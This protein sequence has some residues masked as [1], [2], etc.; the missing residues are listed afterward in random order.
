MKNLTSSFLRTSRNSRFR[1]ILPS[2]LQKTPTQAFS[3]SCSSTKTTCSQS[4]SN[5]IPIKKTEK[6]TSDFFVEQIFTGCLAEYSYYMDSEGE[7]IVIDPIYDHSIYLEL[8]AQRGA[9]IKYVF[10]THFHADFVSGHLNLAKKTGAQ[11][12]FGPLAKANFPFYLSKDQETFKFGKAQLQVLHTPGHTFESSSFV[13]KDSNGIPHSVY[14]GD[15]LFLGEVGRPDLAANESVHPE[16]MAKMLYDSI[17][18][19]LMLLPDNVLVFPGHGA[20]SPCGKSIGIGDFSTIGEQKVSNYAMMKDLKKEDFVKIASSN[21]AR[22]LGYMG[23]DVS[24]NKGN[25]KLREV[26]EIMRNGKKSYQEFQNMLKENKKLVILDTRE[27]ISKGLLKNTMNI[28]L[29]TTF[30]IYVGTMIDNEAPLFVVA[31]NQAKTEESIIR[32]LRVGYDKIVGYLDGGVETWVKNNGGLYNL[33]TIEAEKF[34]EIYEK[35]SHAVFLD[36]RNRAE[37]EDGI[38]KGAKLLPM[39]DIEEELEKGKL[40]HLKKEN[41][42]MYCRTGPR[43]ITTYTLFDK[44]GF[45]NVVNIL[46][47]YTKM[48]ELGFNFVKPT[49]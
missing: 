1:F 25:K 23:H 20:G 36:I 47:G 14:T 13:L 17:R 28:G 21:L 33:K 39:R 7:A 4:A 45:C 5:S 46:G 31:E 12:V 44:Y 19:K 2:L 26:E 41:I 29:N 43:A 38:L 37:W 6:G 49:L 30:S 27:D 32:L 15:T 42:F 24:L 22:P 48:K 11:I 9:K 8:A 3:T 34:K 40:N 16:D 10:E 18:K 35:G